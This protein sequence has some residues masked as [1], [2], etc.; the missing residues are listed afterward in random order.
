M[1]ARQKAAQQIVEAPQDY[2]I[3]EG[4]ESIVGAAVQICPNCHAYRFN[5]NPEDIITQAQLLGAREKQSVSSE[6]LV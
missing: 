3:C 1:D 4:C 6:D 2:K 5:E